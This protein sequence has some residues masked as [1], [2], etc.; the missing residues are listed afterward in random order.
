VKSI[1]VQSFWRLFHSLDPVVQAQAREAYE[2]FKL[3]P[4]HPALRFKKLSGRKSEWSVRINDQ[5]RSVGVRDGD[6]IRWFWIGTH[7]E[8][9]KLF[10]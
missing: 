10:T 1:A 3:D 9:D 2:R 8:F 5:Y 4:H 6:T 7:N